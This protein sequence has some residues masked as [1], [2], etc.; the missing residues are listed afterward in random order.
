MP[1]PDE[2]E[3]INIL[4]DPKLLENNKR[5]EEWIISD[6]IWFILWFPNA[7]RDLEQM[8]KEGIFNIS[9]DDLFSFR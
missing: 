1:N 2:L 5:L 3:I 8:Q 4:K 6:K 7:K 9:L